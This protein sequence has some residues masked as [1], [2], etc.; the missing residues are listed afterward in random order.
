MHPTTRPLP[1]LNHRCLAYDAASHEPFDLYISP[2]GQITGA[3][4]LTSGARAI[5]PAHDWAA[6]CRNRG[7]W[8][9]PPHKQRS[10]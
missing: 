3:T 5:F 7:W 9:D 8:V 10:I 2:A 1:D 4:P 6:W